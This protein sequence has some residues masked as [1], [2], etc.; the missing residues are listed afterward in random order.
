ML[1]NQQFL[2]KGNFISVTMS[3]LQNVSSLHENSAKKNKQTG[4]EAG[5]HVSLS[6][7]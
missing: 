6:I 5:S 4:T 2:K 1:L 7:R 3:V